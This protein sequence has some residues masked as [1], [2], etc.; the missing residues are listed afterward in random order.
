MDLYPGV[1]L[2]P[3]ETPIVILAEGCFGMPQSKTGTGVIR[4]GDWPVAAVIDS[5]YAGKTVQDITSIPSQA[6]I[7]ATLVEALQSSLRPKALLI[8]TAP[9][10]GGLPD[11]YKAVVKEAIEAGLHVISGLHIFLNE[12]PELKTLAGQKGVTL[13]DVRDVGQENIVAQQL[14]RPESVKV[15]TMVGTDCSVGK[16][17]TALEINQQLNKLGQPSQFVATG[18]TGIMIS[19]SGIPLD[20]VIGDFMAGYIEQ[21]IQATIETHHPR[22]VI[23]EGQGSLLHPAYS[24]VT[25][26]LIH[27]SA[28]D[29]LVLCHNP[30]LKAIRNFDKIPLPS[31]S[32]FIQ[33]YESA[34]GWIKPAKVYGI[35]LNTSAFSEEEAISLIKTYEAETG[36]PVTDPVRFGVDKIVEALKKAF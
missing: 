31:L 35:S 5:Q 33:L 22:W 9:M 15:I 29:G 19:G 21:A 1:K 23:I 4:Y 6:P 12:L 20:R 26:S 34:V 8:G 13:W 32:Q 27:G 7:V 2:V 16:M 18:Q 3:T 17:F 30:K 28:P 25:M 36:L 24:G 10:G 14:S 11:L